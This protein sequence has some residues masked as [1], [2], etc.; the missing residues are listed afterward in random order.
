VACYLLNFSKGGAFDERVL[1]AQGKD[2]MAVGLWGLNARSPYLSEL[3]Q[4]DEIVVYVGSPE[5]AVVGHGQLACGFRPWNA[6]ERRRY[7]G[8][9]D[10]GVAFE[11][12]EVWQY[13]LPIRTVRSALVLC[14]TNREP[15]F[16]AGIV[17]LREA[18]LR[19]I[20][21]AGQRLNLK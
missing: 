13:E 5:R 4:G 2:L 18:D 7:P 1:S 6:D 11:H 16:L 20:V 3:E 21:V 9:H 14:Q 10:A 8:P 19:T 12:A 15:R 17:R